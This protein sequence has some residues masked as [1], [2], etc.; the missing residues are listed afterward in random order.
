MS[1]APPFWHKPLQEISPDQ[2]ES[3]CDGCAKCCLHRLED[4]DTGEIHFTNVSCRFLDH[5][6]CRCCDYAN[7]SRNVPQCVQVTLEILEDPYWLP[8]TCAYRILAE[9][10]PLP[11]WHPLISG[12]SESVRASGNGVCGKVVCES[13]ADDL[14]H[15][16]IDW[17]Q[18]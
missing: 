3:L 14:L 8:D 17:V 15:H 2:W 1:K 6:N 18:A 7:R 13:E 11:D 9:G 10:K 5:D 16:L 4:E 12:S